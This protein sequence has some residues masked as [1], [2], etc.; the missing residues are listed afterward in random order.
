MDQAQTTQVRHRR[1]RQ[2]IQ[3]LLRLFSKSNVSVKE[4]CRDHNIHPANFHKWRA[5]YKSKVVSNPKSP[6]FSSIDIIAAPPN[7]FPQLFAEVKGIRV[8]QPV[9]AMFLKELMR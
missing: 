3:E 4:F 9:S 6:G 5:R 7:T 2:Q 1:S 8:Y